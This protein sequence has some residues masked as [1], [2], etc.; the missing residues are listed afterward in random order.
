M[1][2]LDII[3]KAIAYIA[4]LKTHQSTLTDS[5]ASANLLIGDLRSKL[6]G[7]NTVHSALI[8]RANRAEARVASLEATS[9]QLDT[10]SAALAEAINDHPETPTVDPVTLEVVPDA[11]TAG[12]PVTGNATDQVET[13][14][15]HTQ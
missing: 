6:D 12:D 7:E 13:G 8:D 3:L 4:N 9:A 15:V 2:L 11:V 5:L 14:E 10:Q 1:S